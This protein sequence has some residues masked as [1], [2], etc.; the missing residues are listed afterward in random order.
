MREKYINSEVVRTII[1]L[2]LFIIGLILKSKIILFSV[3]ILCGYDIFINAFKNILNKEIFDENFLMIVAT[4]GAIIIGELPEAV[5]VM[6]FYQIGE[7]FQDYAVSKSKKSISELVK[8]RPDSA[9]LCEDDKIIKTIPE[10]LSIGDII[11][12]KA[13][14]KVPIDGIVVEGNSFLNTFALTGES[15][16][17]KVTINDKIL[18]GSINMDG[19]LK[20]KVTTNF[21]DSTVNKILELIENSSDKKTKSEKFI[22]KFSKIYTPFVCVFALVIC[23]VI[24]CILN[25]SYLE[26][27]YKAFSFLVISCPCALIISVPLGFFSGLGVSSSKGILIKGSNFLEMLPNVKTIIF[28]KTGTLTEGKFVVR[29]VVCDNKNRNKMIKYATYAEYYSNHPIAYSLKEY[30]K[31]NISEDKIKSINEITGMGVYAVIDDKKVLVGN[32]K[33]LNKYHIKYDKAIDDGSAVYV[34]IDNEF[35][36]YF[37]INDEIKKGTYNALKELKKNK[38]EKIIMLSGDEEEICKG[39]ANKLKIDE[40]YSELLPQDKVRIVEDIRKKSAGKIMFVGDGIND[41]AALVL[42]DIGV[43]MGN[44]GSDAAIESS[45]IVIMDDEISKINDAIVISNKTLKIV[46]E[47]IFFS[48]FAKIFVLLL[49]LFGLSTMWMAVFADVGV[50]FIAVLNSLRLI[51]KC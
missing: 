43:S 10:S 32:N 29:K 46:K 27:L 35:I 51:K 48:I 17:K 13:G 21:K 41:A 12:I 49:S 36:G 19:T 38:V 22:T 24:P 11:L 1:G 7:L 3:Y 42:S 23:T 5:C 47:N 2:L 45:D 44:I 6:L 16:L 40:Y 9:N 50:T 8:I 37:V 30:Y 18:S 25:E 20:I 26:W 28:D 33:L 15:R 34:A 31:K 14:E 39:V 4:V